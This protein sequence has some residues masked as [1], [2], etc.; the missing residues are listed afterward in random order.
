MGLTDLNTKKQWRR[1]SD[2][3]TGWSPPPR[4]GSCS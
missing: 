1:Y 2:G 4:F 3:L